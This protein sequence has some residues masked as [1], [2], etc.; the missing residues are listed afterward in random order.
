MSSSA[1]CRTLFREPEGVEHLHQAN[2]DLRF[3]LVEEVNVLLSF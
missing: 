2:P 3:F 1:R